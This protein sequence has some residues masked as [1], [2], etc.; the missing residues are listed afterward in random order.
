MNKWLRLCSRPGGWV[1]QG[2]GTALETQTFCQTAKYFKGTTP[3]LAFNLPCGNFPE[4]TPHGKFQVP[5]PNNSCDWISRRF[6]VGIVC[7]YTQGLQFLKIIYHIGRILRL[8]ARSYLGDP[9][10]HYWWYA[11]LHGIVSGCTVVVCLAAWWLR[12][13]NRPLRD[14]SL[15]TLHILTAVNCC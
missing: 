10:G 7:S 11:W 2:A 1:W 13:H 3:M 6:L 9:G 8:E 5:K 4:N 15:Q 14:P 12:M